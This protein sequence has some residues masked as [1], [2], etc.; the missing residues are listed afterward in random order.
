[1]KQAIIAV[2]LVV[3]IIA[4]A[5]L[6]G[7]DN[8][9]TGE[10]SSH[11]FGNTDSS[12]KIVEFA[13]FECP[14][15]GAFFPIVDQ[16]KEKYKDE[17]SFQF[18][19]FPL[20]Q[21]HRNAL[22]AHRAAEAA[23][24]QGKFFEMHDLLYQNLEDWNGPSQTDQV[25]VTI[26]QAIQ[27]FEQYAA[28]L[29]LDIDQFRADV[30]DSNTLGIINADTAAGKSEYQVSGTPTFILN[31]VKIDDT[32]TVDTVEEFSALIDKALGKTPESADVTPEALAPEEIA[33]TEDPTQGSTDTSQ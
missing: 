7:K 31:G 22:A 2:V 13:D 3:G 25:G 19:H 5:V 11:I 9:I 32:S 21:I 16:I 29:E 28:Q 15:C 17:I 20:V 14:A 26:Q 10:Q 12:V 30:E 18:K 23:S 8:S 1:M 6:F 27:I 24:K 4:G 33:P